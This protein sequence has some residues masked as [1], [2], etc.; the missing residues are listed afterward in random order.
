V[1]STTIDVLLKERRV[2]KPPKEFVEQTNVKRWM[3]EHGIRDYEELFE[4]ARDLEWFWGE[5]SKDLVEWYTP[6]RKVLEWN[7]PYAKWFV[8][9]KYNI[10]HDAL[11]KH[12]KT[13][14]KNKVA[15]IFEGEPG[16]VRKLTYRDLSVEVNKLANALKSIGIKKGDRVGLYLPMIPELPIS[17]LACAKIGAIHSVVFSGFSVGGLQ[18]RIADAEAKVLITCDSFYRRGKTVPLKTQVDEAVKGTP[19]VESVIVYKRTGEEIPWR[20]ERDRWWHAL[21]EGQSTECETEKLDAN[22]TLYVL[23]TSGTTG[24]PK[25]VVCDHGGYAVG[26]A[27]TLKWVFDVKD[28][29]I[30]WC[31]ADIGWVTGHSYIVYAP[32][33]LGAT[34]VLFEGAPD[35]PN[36]DRW[37][38]IVEK[39]G[40]TLFYTSP[41]A[42][43]MHMRYGEKWAKKHDLRSLRLLGTVGETIN[44][45]AWMW[46]YK[47]IGGERC[48]IMDTWWQTETGSFVISPL[49]TTPLKP[50][51]TAKPLPG[52]T[53]DVYDENGKPITQGGGDLYLLTPWPAMLRGLY[54][55]PERY[56]QVYWS[57]LP[58]KY[59]TGDKARK[60]E[61]GYLWIQGRADDILKVAGHRIGNYEVESALVSHR[62]VAEA[63]VIGKPHE[64]KGESIAAFVV[65]KEGVEPNDELRRELIEHVAHEVGKIARPDEVWFVKDVPKTRSGKIM[66]RVVRAR[67]LGEPLGDLSTLRNPEAV[68]EIAYAI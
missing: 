23:Y 9:A 61:D 47:H 32:L 66:R 29:D 64:I 52:F 6:Y 7:E 67:A 16:D 18:K 48:Q 24:E 34:S 36:P 51:S 25:G 46:Y 30:W 39:Y 35:H 17:M 40:V 55:N 44:P 5:V 45:E 11:D 41:T 59:L 1:Q 20:E 53:A 10:V 8:G 2:F 50:G 28:E 56:Q 13:Y 54:K 33:I 19:S 57:K 42:I 22:D 63:V 68:D 60:D 62:K 37:W 38:S 21:C 27:L 26:T 43:R 14:R 12:L 58:H 31:T 49:P 4:K 15:F 3:D 65:L